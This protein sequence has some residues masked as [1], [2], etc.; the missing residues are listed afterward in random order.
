MVIKLICAT[1]YASWELFSRILGTVPVERQMKPVLA[2]GERKDD[3]MHGQGTH[4][5][6]DGPKYVGG[7]KAG[8][9]DVL[10]SNVG[11]AMAFGKG[12]AKLFLFR[13]I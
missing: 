3:R 2:F 11:S 8:E 12:Q 7:W 4:T 9:L 6:A 10:L 13:M 1:Q 5:Y